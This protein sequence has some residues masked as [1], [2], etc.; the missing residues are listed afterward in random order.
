MP[1][2]FLGFPG[3]VFTSTSTIENRR[4]GNFFAVLAIAEI[5]V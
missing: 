4:S 3:R 5:C 2:T 1:T